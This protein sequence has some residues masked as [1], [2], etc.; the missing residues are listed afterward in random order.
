MEQQREPPERA[1]VDGGGV[2]R[3]RGAVSGRSL[4]RAYNAALEGYGSGNET[5]AW[6]L[7]PNVTRDRKLL[8]S[9][10]TLGRFVEVDG[11]LSILG[12]PV[13]IDPELP[14][15]AFELRERL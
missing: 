6:Y 15:G 2:L 3:I 9:F 11:R 1:E 10:W 8:A 14:D 7:S 5:R 4:Q 12:L 13:E